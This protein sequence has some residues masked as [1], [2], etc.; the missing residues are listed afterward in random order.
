M[1]NLDQQRSRSWQ[2]R[3]ETAVRLAGTTAGPVAD[4]GCGNRRLRRL[5]A[6]DY[7]GY[8]LVPQHRTVTAVDLNREM[9]PG[10]V[11]LAF[12]LGVIEYLDDPGLFLKRLRGF[13]DR[14]VVS[15]VTID[16]RGPLTDHYRD[17]RRRKGWVTD[18][19]AAEVRRLCEDAEWRIDGED[20]AGRNHLLALR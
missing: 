3:A 1:F 5:V 15:Y 18:L 17:T 8:D 4:L 20:D 2:D 11:G 19:T 16:A 14:A 6:G 9:P 12:A 10:R 13:T 7:R